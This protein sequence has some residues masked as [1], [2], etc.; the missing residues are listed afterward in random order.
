[1]LHIAQTTSFKFIYSP[2]YV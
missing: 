2:V 1:V